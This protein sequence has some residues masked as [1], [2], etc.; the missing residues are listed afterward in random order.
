MVRVLSLVAVLC[1]SACSKGTPTP[2]TATLTPKPAA[3]PAS[4]KLTSQTG[5]AG[6]AAQAEPA[7]KP[8][9]AQL[10]EVVARVNGETI[11]KADFDKAVKN[12]EARAGSPVPA[13]QRDRIYRGLLD[14]LI[15]YKLLQQETKTRKVVVA[16][17]DVD[18]RVAQIRQQFPNEEAFKQALQQQNVTLEQLK[19]DAR[20]DMAVDKLIG[21]S[22]AS[23]VVVKPEDIQAFYQANQDHFKQGDR[24]RASHILITVPQNAD[25]PT[26]AAAKAKAE[27]LLK[28]IKAGKDFGEL[29]KANSQDPGSAPNGGDLGYF[30]QGEMVGP[31]NDVAFSLKP[32]AVSDVVETQFGY[33]IIKVVDKQAGG[34]VPFDQ[35]KGQIQQYL[36]QQSRQKETESFVAGL[37]SKGKVEIYI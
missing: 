1:L 24:V 14:Q 37:R 2:A 12:I 10:P 13:D 26:K 25:A 36:E 31:F 16:D 11:T 22:I 28:Q 5:P 21:D 34:V 17:A 32:G 23:K 27:D 15:G 29:A 4:A 9:P 20:A 6:A 19:A 30:Q 3:V 35:A 18:A 33:H 8:V 7:V